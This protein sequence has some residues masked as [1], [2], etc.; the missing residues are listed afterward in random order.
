MKKK[1]LIFDLDW[2]LL[3]EQTKEFFPWVKDFIKKM[4]QWYTMFVS[5]R[6]SDETAREI[7]KNAGVYDNFE[8]VMWSSVMEKWIKHIEVFEMVSESDSFDQK[9][10]FIWDWEI[11][12]A[13]AYEAGLP[14]IK[15]WKEWIDRLEAD[16][17]ID[18]EELIKKAK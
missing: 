9:A 16:S 1:Y 14:F 7:L 17:V 12:R 2:T 8:V 4:S 6:S 11:D 5:T 15:I 3:D 10:V 18:I 13:T